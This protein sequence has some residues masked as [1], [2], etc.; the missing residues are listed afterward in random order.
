MFPLQVDPN[1]YENHWYGSRSPPRRRKVSRG[2]A[3]FALLVVL[4]AGGGA[5]L[6]SVH[7]QHDAPGYQDWE[8]E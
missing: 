7:I 8:M 3:R 5:V 6:G 4:L 1:W 2:V